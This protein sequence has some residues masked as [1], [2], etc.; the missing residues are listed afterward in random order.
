MSAVET[1]RMLAAGARPASGLLHTARLEAFGVEVYGEEA[2]VDSFRRAPFDLSDA[3]KIVVAI[4]HI[5]IFDG[6][7]A[8]FADLSGESIARIWCLGDGD[9]V[10]SEPQISVVFDP[11]LA[12]SRGDVFMAASDHAALAADAV[13]STMLAG[14][15]IAR[16]DPDS[17]LT[18]A[19]A[20]RAF[21]TAAEGAA[22]FAVYRLAGKPDRTSGFAM[23][24][25]RWT[26]DGLQIVRDH[27]GEDA[28]A[29]R[30]WTPRIGA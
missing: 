22:L 17:Y 13:E 3:A 16:D 4:G 19:F 18:R 26:P 6:E 24:A 15:A 30:A 29:E 28:V 2:I 5:A 27:V 9:P 11:D 8:L 20:I 25:A 10:E 21:G 12:Q 23:A 7:T 1:L 14:R